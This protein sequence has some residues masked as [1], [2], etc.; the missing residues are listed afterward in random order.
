MTQYHRIP[1]NFKKGHFGCVIFDANKFATNI[2]RR[3]PTISEEHTKKV[4]LSEV[5]ASQ[6]SMGNDTLKLIT[7]KFIVLQGALACWI[8][9]TQI[10]PL[11]II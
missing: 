6:I 5:A 4:F 7:P 11:N 2:F 3:H 9:L 1:G 10:Y 8:K